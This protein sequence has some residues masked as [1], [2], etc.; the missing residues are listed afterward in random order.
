VSDR[1]HFILRTWL[2]AIGGEFSFLIHEVLAIPG[3]IELVFHTENSMKYQSLHTIL[4]YRFNIPFWY[5]ILI[6]CT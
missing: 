2:S 1:C 3:G 6:F 4:K 5:E